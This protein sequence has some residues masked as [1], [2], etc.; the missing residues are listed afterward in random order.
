MS[1]LIA[2][3]SAGD[4]GI[5]VGDETSDATETYEDHALLFAQARK[6][7]DDMARIGNLSAQDFKAMLVD[8]E[9]MV[10]RVIDDRRRSRSQIQLYTRNLSITTG[11]EDYPGDPDGLLLDS[12][13]DEQIWYNID[14]EHI[15]S[16]V[17]LDMKLYK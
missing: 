16:R 3:S 17:G 1:R 13:L 10:Q 15:S 4:T 12:I 14:W 9:T 6:L 5:G 7:L 2:S 8:V 11:T